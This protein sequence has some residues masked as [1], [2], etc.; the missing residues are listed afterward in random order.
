MFL[1]YSSVVVFVMLFIHTRLL[2]LAFTMAVGIVSGCVS[3]RHTCSSAEVLLL[4]TVS[5]RRCSST[6]RDAGSHLLSS[7]YRALVFCKVF[8][9]IKT[10]IHLA[11][12]TPPS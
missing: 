10:P 6:E 2:C 12:C 11:Y 8:E 4:K 3:L 5:I 1:E 7:S 9:N